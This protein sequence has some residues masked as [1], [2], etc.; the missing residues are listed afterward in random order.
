M[1][2][3][4]CGRVA[5]PV[6]RVG[7]GH[8]NI[9]GLGLDSVSASRGIRHQAIL[10]IRIHRGNHVVTRNCCDGVAGPSDDNVF[11]TG[12]YG[13]GPRRVQGVGRTGQSVHRSANIADGIRPAQ[14]IDRA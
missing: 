8:S 10:A 12:R 11:S 4:S 14:D 3:R 9:V 6:Y 13:V 7:R 1:D 5:D 2:G